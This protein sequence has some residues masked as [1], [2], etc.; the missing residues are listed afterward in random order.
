[1]ETKVNTVDSGIDDERLDVGEYGIHEVISHILLARVVE[2]FACLDVPRRVFERDDVHRGNLR[3]RAFNC[4]IVRNFDSPRCARAFRSANTVRC[5]SGDAISGDSRHSAS[6]NCS[7]ACR[8]SRRDILAICCSL[9]T[10]TDYNTPDPAASVCEFPK[11]T[12]KHFLRGLEGE[13]AH[14]FEVTRDKKVV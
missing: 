12:D 11:S 9:I 13:V 4:A 7:I 2:A 5:Q 3:S 8:R 10:A 14:V 1:M 6:H